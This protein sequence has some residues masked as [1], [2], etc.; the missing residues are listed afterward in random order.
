[1]HLAWIKTP[2]NK[3]GLGTIKIPII[4]DTTKVGAS[5]IYLIIACQL[6]CNTMTRGLYAMYIT[7][8]HKADKLLLPSYTMTTLR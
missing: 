2:R 4:A 6:F 3:G 1:M 8:H 5:W 7:Q